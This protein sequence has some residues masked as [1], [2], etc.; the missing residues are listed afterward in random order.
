[1]QLIRI[2]YHGTCPITF[3]LHI[4]EST[5]AVCGLSKGMKAPLAVADIY[6]KCAICSACCLYCSKS[7][8]LSNS[9]EELSLKLSTI[10]SFWLSKWRTFSCRCLISLPWLSIIC[11]ISCLLIWSEKFAAH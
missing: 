2:A 5:L 8:S 1:M 9:T 10:Y 4:Y 11:S 3:Y 6:A 7:F